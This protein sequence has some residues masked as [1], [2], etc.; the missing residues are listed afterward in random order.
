MNLASNKSLIDSN[1][2]SQVGVNVRRLYKSNNKKR[3]ML[4]A[5]YESLVLGKGNLRLTFLRV[6]SKVKY[7]TCYSFL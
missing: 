6:I 1:L 2:K 5:Q 7:P 3:S 4:H